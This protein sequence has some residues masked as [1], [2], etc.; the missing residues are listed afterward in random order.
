M[1]GALRRGFAYLGRLSHQ[2]AKEA[3]AINNQQANV[4]NQVGPN[5]RE[6]EAWP[7]CGLRNWGR[8]GDTRPVK[9]FR[10][11]FRCAH[12]C[13]GRRDARGLGL[14]L[15]LTAPTF[16]S[17]SLRLSDA[18]LRKRAAS[19]PPPNERAN[20][21]HRSAS[22]R[23]GVISRQASYSKHAAVTLMRPASA[24]SAG[25]CFAWNG[26]CERVL[27]V[28]RLGAYAMPNYLLILGDC[29][30]SYRPVNTIGCTD[31]MVRCTRAR[32]FARQCEVLVR[33]G[34]RIVGSVDRAP[35]TW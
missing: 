18:I 35:G 30:G 21:R 25:T 31:D 29:C 4:L 19:P 2:A 11:L 24:C 20:A 7:L 13:V 5:L 34:H 15:L 28:S 33:G 1:A 16:P 22:A 26:P 10:D 23:N 6:G 3:L 12:L 8:P 9:E 27:T 17:V 14:L 32:P